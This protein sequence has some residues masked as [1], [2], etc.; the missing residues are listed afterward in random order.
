MDRDHV[1]GKTGARKRAGDLRFRGDPGVPVSGG[2]LRKLVDSLRRPVRPAARHLRRAVGG[3]AAVLRVR[4]LHPDRH[5]H[6][7][8]FG[9]QERHPDRGIREGKPRAREKCARGRH[10]SRTPSTAAYSDDLVR[11]HSGRLS[12]GDRDRRQ[13]SGPAFTRHRRIRRHADRDPAG[14]LYRAG[15]LRPDRGIRRTAA[16]RPRRGA[17]PGGCPMRA[18]FWI[19]P[20][21]FL[22]GCAVGPNY[23]R[24]QVPVPDAFRNAPPSPGTESIGDTNWQT[25]FSDDTLNGIVSKSLANNFD[26]RIAAERAQEA[27]AQ[28]G[29][30]RANQYPFLDAQGGLTASRSSSVGASTFLPAGTRLRSAYTTLGAAV[31]WELD[32]WGRL[33]RLTEAAR[34]N[35]LATEEG[36]HAVQVS[37]VSD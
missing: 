15:A 13:L 3:P 20:L 1:P 18:L 30:T 37:L 23:H 10:R 27:R 21:A 25:L 35:Y 5:R 12:L 7:D 36:R 22:S 32:L 24:P 6:P 33:R 34:A 4:H 11:L 8:W 14:R 16:A 29:I 31:S 9:G 17:E 26:L 28:L 19:L 2:S